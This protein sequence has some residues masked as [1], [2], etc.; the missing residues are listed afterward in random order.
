MATTGIINGTLL[1]IYKDGVAIGHAVTCSLDVSMATRET[2]TKDLPGA[3][4]TTFEP[5]KKS[6]TLSTD[7]LVAF[8][9][10]NESVMDLFD[11]LDNNE[12]LV[13]RFDTGGETG[14]PFWQGTGYCTA[15]NMGATVEENVTYSATFTV[16]GAVVKGTN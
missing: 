1:R 7:G 4:W 15:F 8:D 16:S 11:A 3:G 12:V 13:I 2:L 10:P 9:T 14:D 6:G 5:G